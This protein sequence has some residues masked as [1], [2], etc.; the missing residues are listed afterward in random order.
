MRKLMMATMLA[1]M[2]MGGVAEA[3]QAYIPRF[4]MPVP[5]PTCPFRPGC[6]PPRV[7]MPQPLDLTVTVVPTIAPVPVA[8]VRR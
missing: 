3:G 5:T 4:P 2:T 8:V 6:V 1:V 7:P